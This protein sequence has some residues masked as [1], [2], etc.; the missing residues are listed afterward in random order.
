MIVAILANVVS[1]RRFSRWDWTANRRYSLTPATVQTLHDLSETIQIWVLFGPADPLEQSV[2]QM[3]VAYRAEAAK[4]DG[5]YV[6]PGRDVVALEDVRKR[7]KIETGR[8]EQGHVVADAIVVVARGDKHW[9]LSTSDMV[10][11]SS[12]NDTQVK[13]KEERALTGAIRNVLGSEKAKLCF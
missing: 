13:P 10:E 4:P 9:F 12:G 5:R 11:I 3:L 1:A 8:T 2:K 7:F 6:D